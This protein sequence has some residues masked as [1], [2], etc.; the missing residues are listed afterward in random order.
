MSAEDVAQRVLMAG[1]VPLWIL[2]GLVDWACHRRTRIERTSG[3]RENVFHWVLL[4]EGGVALVATA[5]LQPGPA[6]LAIVLAAFAAHELTTYVELRYTAPRREIRP[7][8]QMVHSFM[9]L[10]PLGLFALLAVLAAGEQP[11]RW[12]A[13]YLFVVGIAVLVLNVL[14]LAEESWRCARARG[15][16]AGRLP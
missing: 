8:E 4:A 7:F 13:G 12:P 1:L 3:L 9:E 5:L 11:T 16:G 14:P 6:L 15:A 10:L 2:A